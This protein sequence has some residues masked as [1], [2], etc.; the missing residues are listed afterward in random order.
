MSDDGRPATWWGAFFETEDW[1]RVQLGWGSL[2][3]AGEQADR[4]IRALALEPGER[5]LDVPC[6][7]GRIAIEL[8][9]HGMR[10]TG[11]DMT[12]RFLVAGRE[13]AAARGLRVELLEGDMREPLGVEGFDAALCFWGSF[14]YFDDEGN[15]RQAA[16]VA[17]ALRPGGRYLIDTVTLEV[18]APR[19]RARD[20]F[21]SGGIT[22][23][24]ETA[25]NLGD[26]RVETTWTFRRADA[27]PVVRRSSIRCFTLHELTD[28]LRGA[29]FAAF[30]ALDAELE[31]F[32][33]GSDRLWLVATKGDG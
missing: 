3:D 2:E 14:G 31:P 24:T 20:W 33:L 26:G 11:V 7:D 8:A 16:A 25:L 4:A 13:R 1:Q 18:I 9:D 17:D 10:V 21:E 23:T 27:D 5:V 30:S 19:F 15:R 6:G 29:G 28:L 12:E 32:E 22:V